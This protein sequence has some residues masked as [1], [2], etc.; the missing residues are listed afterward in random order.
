MFPFFSEI[1]KGLENLGL[2][3]NILTLEYDLDSI[4]SSSYVLHSFYKHKFNYDKDEINPTIFFG[5]PTSFSG[6]CSNACLINST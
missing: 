1:W 3:D 6:A 2:T 5:F 4:V